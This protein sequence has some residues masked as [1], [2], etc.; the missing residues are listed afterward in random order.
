MALM[1]LSTYAVR[2]ADWVTVLLAAYLF[3][4]FVDHALW[5]CTRRLVR[6]CAVE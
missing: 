6:A 3:G 5:V 1:V 4:A 2:N